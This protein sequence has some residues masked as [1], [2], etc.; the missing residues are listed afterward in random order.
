MW[1][2]HFARTLLN[3]SAFIMKFRRERELAK[4]FLYDYRRFSRWSSCWDQVQTKQQL[5]ARI[6]MDY[7]RI[8]KGLALPEVRPGFGKQVCAG[9]MLSITDYVGRYGVDALVATV[10]SSLNEYFAWQASQ[11]IPMDGLVC[12]FG[13]LRRLAGLD[14]VTNIRD[15]GTI[16]GTVEVTREEILR[17]VASGPEHF[18]KSRHS[19]RNFSNDEVLID[20]LSAAVGLALYTPSVCNRQ[21][22]KVYV[23]TDRQLISSALELQNGNR[24]F[25]S[26]INKVLI[27]TS[28]LECFTSAGERNQGWIDGGLFAMSLVYALHGVG[29]ASCFLNWSVTHDRDRELRKRIAI[30]DS[31]VIITFIGVGRYPDSLRVARSRRKDLSDVM[32]VL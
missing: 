24:G 12:E 5:A 17:D 29:I 23:L 3:K 20:D 6:T 28:T 27:I 13:A 18:F 10:V 14:E 21:A 15:T 19:V 16:G 25:T 2:P 26:S 8:E 7:H 11:G 30:P 4:N 31:E 1:M 9:L 32:V 22:W